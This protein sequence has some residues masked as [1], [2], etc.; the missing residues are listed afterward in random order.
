MKRQHHWLQIRQN[1]MAVF[2]IKEEDDSETLKEALQILDNVATTCVEY[3][4]FYGVKK[5]QH[6]PIA[7][8]SFMVEQSDNASNY[9]VDT[10]IHSDCATLLTQGKSRSKLCIG[11]S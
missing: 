7:L 2:E 6:N 3:A 5:I 1:L 9:R 11:A 4:C 8:Q 10:R